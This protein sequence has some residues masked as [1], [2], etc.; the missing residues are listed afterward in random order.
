MKR[1]LKYLLAKESVQ[2]I[3]AVL[4]A[5][6]VSVLSHTYRFRFFGVEGIKKYTDQNKPVLIAFW[7][8]RSLT[9]P[10]FWKTKFKGKKGSAVFSD[11]KDGRL[12]RNI[13][14]QFG[15][16]PIVGSSNRKS[17]MAAKGIMSALK[18]GTTVAMTPDGPTGPRMRLTTESL[19][20]F[21]GRLNIPIFIFTPSSKNAKVLKSWDRFMIPRPFASVDIQ[22]SK[23]FFVKKE[24]SDSLEKKD[25]LEKK[26][27]E[28][29]QKL[30]A[31]NGLSKI[32]PQPKDLKRKSRL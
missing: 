15:V 29:L 28:A 18:E 6:I 22:M 25:L 12:M 31:K 9:L 13:C 21:A 20:F 24:E 7:H 14:A 30:D 16:Q 17:V 8:G 1:L 27:I 5:G 19:I 32:E 4:I 10:Y 11:H 23:P 2:K 3:L 26:M